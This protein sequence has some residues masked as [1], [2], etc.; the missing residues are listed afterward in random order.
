MASKPRLIGECHFFAACAFWV[1]K[2]A[3]FDAIAKSFRI[4]TD[5]AYLNELS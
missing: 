4:N 5:E 3:V 2:L 1:V